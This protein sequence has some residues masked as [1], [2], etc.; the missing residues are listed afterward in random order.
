[1]T[2]ASMP[3]G[4][5]SP[6]R[7][8]LLGPFPGAASGSAGAQA[9][10]QLEPRPDAVLGHDPL[11]PALHRAFG[12][13]ELSGDGPVGQTGGEQVEHLPVG[14]WEPGVPG[15]LTVEAAELFGSLPE[16]LEQRVQ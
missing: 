4:C 16:Q 2:P 12:D 7:R 9:Q 1:M 3:F 13:T 10:P 6:A 14:L 15:S 11:D 5:A 8:S